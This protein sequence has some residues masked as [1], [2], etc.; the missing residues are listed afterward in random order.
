[1]ETQESRDRGA[2]LARCFLNRLYRIDFDRAFC[3]PRAGPEPLGVILARTFKRIA[4]DLEGAKN[5][6]HT[7]RSMGS[8]SRAG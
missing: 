8:K 7:G 2:R 6:I 1:M 3:F 4:D 5:G